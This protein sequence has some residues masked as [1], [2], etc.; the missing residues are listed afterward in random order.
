MYVGMCER[1]RVYVGMCV[2]ICGYVGMCERERVCMWVCVSVGMWVCV[3]FWSTMR[4]WIKN[5]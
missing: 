5:T 3:V 2:C 4:T 1:E